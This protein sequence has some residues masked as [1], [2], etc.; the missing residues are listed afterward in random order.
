MNIEKLEPQE[1]QH[2]NEG[3]Y[4]MIGDERYDLD[5][6]MRCDHIPEFH[7]FLGLTNSHGMA[8]QLSECGESVT[9]AY[10]G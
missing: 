3:S 6:F 4:F 8:I 7:A 5:D 10:V 1:I 2:D 9:P